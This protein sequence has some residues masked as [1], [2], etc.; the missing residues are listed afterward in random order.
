MQR[1]S[2]MKMILVKT[3]SVLDCTHADYIPTF[4]RHSKYKYK[5]ERIGKTVVNVSQRSSS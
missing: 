1:N 2:G 5:I 3:N 4:N